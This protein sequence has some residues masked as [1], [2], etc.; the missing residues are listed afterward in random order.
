VGEGED[1][2]LRLMMEED[3][4]DVLPLYDTIYSDWIEKGTQ[5]KITVPETA[6]RTLRAYLDADPHGCFV[7]QEK[8][9]EGFAFSHCWGKVGWLGPLGVL[10]E[11]RGKGYGKKLTDACVKYLKRNG[12]AIIGLETVSPQNIGLYLKCGFFPVLPRVRLFKKVERRRMPP[13]LEILSDPSDSKIV[14]SMRRICSAQEGGLDY[15]GEI[16]SCQ[17]HEVGKT[18]LLRRSGE[19][20]GYAFLQTLPSREEKRPLGLIKM[21]GIHPDFTQKK[22]LHALL[23]GCESL[24]F[25]SGREEISIKVYS[26]YRA[27]TLGLLEYGYTIQSATLRMLLCGTYEVNEKLYCGYAWSS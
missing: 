9:I 14:S 6:I 5:R 20:V 25:M 18:L 22:S 19:I 23:D 11:E 21:L 15:V 13:H 4:E 7:L 2:N 1:M 24:A 17:R 3:L 16:L 10:Q 27:L 12:C 8:S 26:G